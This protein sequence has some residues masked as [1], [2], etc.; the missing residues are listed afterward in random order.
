SREV[1]KS[2][3][4][5]VDNLYNSGIFKNEGPKFDSSKPIWRLDIK[6]LSDSGQGFLTETYLEK[7][8][9]KA[10]RGGVRGLN[11]LVVLD[12]A[13]KYMTTERDHIVNKMACEAR[14]FGV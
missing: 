8:F 9:L 10:K 1:L 4:D 5:R 7:I 13:Q 11:T 14:K 3:Y 6:S 12:E 2:V